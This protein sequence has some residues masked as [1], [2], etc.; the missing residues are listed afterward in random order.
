MQESAGVALK[1]AAA[2]AT[3]GD[4]LGQLFRSSASSRP[5]RALMRPSWALGSTQCLRSSPPSAS[6][7]P[8]SAIR[9]PFRPPPSGAPGLLPAV[10]HCPFKSVMSAGPSR[11]ASSS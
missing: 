5:R 2:V 11:S 8:L 9:L 7:R 3:I 6:R 10:R 4:L 1:Q